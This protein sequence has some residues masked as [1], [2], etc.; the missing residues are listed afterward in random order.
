MLVMPG[1]DIPTPGD[2]PQRQQRYLPS[3]TV[4]NTHILFQKLRF[5]INITNPTCVM[6]DLIS[7]ISIKH[8]AFIDVQYTTKTTWE[9]WIGGKICRSSPP[10]TGCHPLGGIP[11]SLCVWVS[12]AGPPQCHHCSDCCQTG[13]PPRGSLRASLPPLLIRQARHLT[14]DRSHAPLQSISHNPLRST[15]QLLTLTSVCLLSHHRRNRRLGG[16]VPQMFI[17]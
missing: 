11:N 17:L 1:A 12:P 6:T 8:F 13:P 10:T 9:A 4:S 15:C 14:R 3:V 2:L 16:E 7:L 5:S